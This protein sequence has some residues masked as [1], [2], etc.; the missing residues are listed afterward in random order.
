MVVATCVTRILFAQ[1]STAD[2]P[3][4]QLG[5]I[6]PGES[7][8]LMMGSIVRVSATV[9]LQPSRT[10]ST[11]YIGTITVNG[12]RRRDNGPFDTVLTPPASGGSETVKETLSWFV[13]VRGPKIMK[14]RVQLRGIGISSH[15]A[16]QFADVTRQYPVKCDLRSSVFL[17][18]IERLFG[19]CSK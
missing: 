11:E 18:L 6:L 4:G 12:Q 10:E 15:A 14:L 5:D 7:Q 9:T 16:F 2:G 1:T 3:S 13:H 17:R 8:V 19:C